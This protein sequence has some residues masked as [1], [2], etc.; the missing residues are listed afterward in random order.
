MQQN[1][2]WLWEFH[3][4]RVQ[5]KVGQNPKFSFFVEFC[6]KQNKT[7]SFGNQKT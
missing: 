4:M 7:Y 5:G 1:V 2:V 3:H 6:L